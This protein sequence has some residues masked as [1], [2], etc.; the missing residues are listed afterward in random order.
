MKR[1]FATPKRIVLALALCSSAVYVPAVLAA[2]EGQSRA[3]A[4]TIDERTGRI[5]TEAIEKLNN[6]DFAGARAALDG[7]NKDRLSPYEK[8]RVEQIY[9][10][11][12][13]QA[14][15]YAAARQHME[16]AIA[17]GGFNEVE[18]QQGR[19]QLAQLYMQEENWRE[20]ARALEEWMATAPN[21]SA[22]AYYLLAIAYYQME[23]VDQ[24]LPHARKAVE[25]SENPQEPWLQLLGALLLQKEDY[26]AALPVIQRSLNLYPGRKTYWT[27]LSSIYAAREDYKNALVVLELAYHAGLLTDAADLRRLADLYMVRDMPYRA[28]LLLQENIDK[29]VMQPDFRLY[30]SLANAYIA[31]REFEKSLPI[32]EKAG[33]LADDGSMF[34]RLGE[35]NLQLENWEAAAN[36]FQQG[37]NKGGLRD[38]ATPQMLMG[39]AYYNLGRYND[40]RTWFQRSRSSENTR[41][42][43]DAYLQLIESK[44]N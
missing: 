36:A 22:S 40:A 34:V 37:L 14:E 6:D 24:A 16:A 43:S 23:Q 19:Y 11:L 26:E 7:L 5:L 39:I 3:T 25:M 18:V 29:G 42:T 10:S 31:A 32:L 30:E 27:Q 2:A 44:Q 12:A 15:D 21:P 41:T 28:A 20:G 9:F 1:F 35:V 13:V 38:T 17:S 33:G 8:S 4:P